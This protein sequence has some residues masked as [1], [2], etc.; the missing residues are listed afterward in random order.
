MLT[1]WVL[2]FEF[3]VPVPSS[4]IRKDPSNYDDKVS[5]RQSVTAICTA[6]VLSCSV[7]FGI[8][9]YFTMRRKHQVQIIRQRGIAV[10]SKF[11]ELLNSVAEVTHNCK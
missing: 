2:Q 3:Y 7:W 1:T 10:L 11:L 5:S 9:N 4:V 6:S 8:L